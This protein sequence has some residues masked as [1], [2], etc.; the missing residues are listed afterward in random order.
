VAG[1]F[2]RVEVVEVAEELIEPMHRGQELVQVAKVILAELSRGI[3]HGLEHRGDRRRGCRHAD[4]RASLTDRG[5]TGADGQHAGDEVRPA[6]RATRLG[7]VVGEQHAAFG[8]LIEVRRPACHHA[9]AVSAD[10][11]DADVVT[12]DADDVGFLVLR[13]CRSAEADRQPEG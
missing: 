1:V 11:P 4:G 13:L 2:H 8:K 3:S 5:Q 9:P 12:H 6:R 7:V 10:V